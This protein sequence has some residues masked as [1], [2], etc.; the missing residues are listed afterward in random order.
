MRI[1]PELSL[2]KKTINLLRFGPRL[3]EIQRL[4]IIAIVMTQV[5][6]QLTKQ[7]LHVF[8][9]DE[10]DQAQSF[11]ELDFLASLEIRNSVE[12]S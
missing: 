9:L 4:Y 1:Q 7:L 6:I 12:V 3:Q 8:S 2:Q 11:E 5:H 10:A